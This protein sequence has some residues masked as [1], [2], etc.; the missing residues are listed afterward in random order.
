LKKITRLSRSSSAIGNSKLPRGRLPE[1]F[2][3]RYSKWP[4]PAAE[5]IVAWL[6]LGGEA[7]VP[8]SP[9]RM[10][11]FKDW[12]SAHER[13]PKYPSVQLAFLTEELT[14]PFMAHIGSRLMKADTPEAAF[15][16]VRP[17]FVA[18]NIVFASQL[19]EETK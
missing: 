11:M 15:E 10:A 5:G 2:Y 6:D 7:L 8:W 19:R 16:I 12:A 4:A 3:L 9:E 13:N 1:S 18:S 14:G 17:Y